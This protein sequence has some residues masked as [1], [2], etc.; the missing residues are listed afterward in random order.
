MWPWEITLPESDNL[1]S[2]LYQG[3]H[4]FAALYRLYKAS[5]W[6][7]GIHIGSNHPIYPKGFRVSFLKLPTHLQDKIFEKICNDGEGFN[8]IIINKGYPRLRVVLRFMF[9]IYRQHKFENFLVNKF[10]YGC[11]NGGLFTSTEVCFNYGPFDP[12]SPFVCPHVELTA[13]RVK[14]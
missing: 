11:W 5:F 4:L 14:T 7:V 13:K 10:G 6:G 2:W 8:E 3:P 9:L 1:D 12:V